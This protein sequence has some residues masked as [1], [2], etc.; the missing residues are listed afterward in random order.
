[1]YRVGR[2]ERN[3]KRVWGTFFLWWIWIRACGASAALAAGCRWRLNVAEMAISD[4]LSFLDILRQAIACPGESV[5]ELRTLFGIT[6]LV[7][8]KH[9]MDARIGTFDEITVVIMVPMHRCGIRHER[10]W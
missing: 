5:F 1:M 3:E 4:I 6:H 8:F 2:L 10:E 9:V 7:I